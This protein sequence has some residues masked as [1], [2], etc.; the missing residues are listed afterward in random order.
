MMQDLLNTCKTKLNE[1]HVGIDSRGIVSIPKDYYTISLKQMQLVYDWIKLSLDFNVKRDSYAI[2]RDV[3]DYYKNQI[4]I[5]N[6]AMIAVAIG[7]GTYYDLDLQ[8]LEPNFP[9]PLSIVPIV[10][11][12]ELPNVDHFLDSS[13]H[14]LLSLKRLN[15][16]EL[17]TL[18]REV[19]HGW[20]SEKFGFYYNLEDILNNPYLLGIYK[21]Q[22][23]IGFL[24]CQ[25]QHDVSPA[26]L[27]IFPSYR[28][29]GWGHII[30]EWIHAEMKGYV[31]RITS[32]PQARSFWEHHGYHP[33]AKNSTEMAKMIL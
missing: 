11:R 10:P 33:I 21:Q 16:T 20:R 29:Q 4:M 7:L 8:T 32:L 15:K 5:S 24:V 25:D 23:F 19:F 27:E 6:G 31:S 13:F 22:D 12:K 1:V 9:I 2:R 28:K 18:H 30:V 3:E 14:P 26:F 17:Q